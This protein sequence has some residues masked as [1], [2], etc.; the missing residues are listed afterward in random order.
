M[1]N[2]INFHGPGQERN[3]TKRN[4]KLGGSPTQRVKKP[5]RL[6]VMSMALCPPTAIVPSQSDINSPLIDPTLRLLT[7]RLTRRNVRRAG[8]QKPL[9]PS[10]HAA[11]SLSSTGSRVM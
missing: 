3:C 9:N 2:N 6:R 4:Q 1:T 11:V 5:V 10:H 7:G 8:K